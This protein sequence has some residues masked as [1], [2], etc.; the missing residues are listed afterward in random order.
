MRQ[1]EE[2]KMKKQKEEQKRYDME[3]FIVSQKTLK[4]DSNGGKNCRTQT[5]VQIRVL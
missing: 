2:E 3:T 5:N 4:M 1:N